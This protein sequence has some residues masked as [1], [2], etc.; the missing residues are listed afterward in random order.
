M[1]TATDLFF[2]IATYIQII[3]LSRFT[4]YWKRMAFI[5]DYK[6]SGMFSECSIKIKVKTGG[7]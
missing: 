4:D 2:R 7:H 5:A 6:W 3:T 1:E